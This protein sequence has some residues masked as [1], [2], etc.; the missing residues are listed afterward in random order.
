MAERLASEAEPEDGRCPAR[1]GDLLLVRR[2]HLLPSAA[3]CR[4]IRS[5]SDQPPISAALCCSLSLPQR[6]HMIAAAFTRRRKRRR[7]SSLLRGLCACRGRA[8]ASNAP[9]RPGRRLCWSSAQQSGRRRVRQLLLHRISTGEDADCV[10][11]YSCSS[12]VWG[13]CRGISRRA[14][15]CRSE[16]SGPA[17]PYC[18][19]QGV[20]PRNAAALS[21]TSGRSSHIQWPARSIIS[22]RALAPMASA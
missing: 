8:Y 15:S 1:T 5:T 20:E 2:E 9:G 14:Q 13:V 21:I 18:A 16:S 17:P 12:S 4:S 7:S 11:A 10:P 22:S 19:F 3:V 6:F